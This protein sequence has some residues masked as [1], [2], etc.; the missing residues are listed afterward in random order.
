MKPVKSPLGVFSF[1]N[2]PFSFDN[3]GDIYSGVSKYRNG[4][5]DWVE[6]VSKL[7][8]NLGKSLNVLT[9][10]SKNALNQI[11]PDFAKKS[12]SEIIEQF[13]KA[14]QNEELKPLLKAVTSELDKKGNRLMK[15]AETLRAL[16]EAACIL[17]ASAL[18]GWFLPWFNIQ[19]TRKLYKSKNQQNNPASAALPRTDNI[20]NFRKYNNY[21]EFTRSLA[22]V[23]I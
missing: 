1:N 23:K 3:I 6:N 4:I 10:K 9:D 22:V 16:P 8:G 17:G 18:L 14:S 11:V 20:Q 12:N 7:G 21:D 5:V 2:K 19:Y 13:R 15:R